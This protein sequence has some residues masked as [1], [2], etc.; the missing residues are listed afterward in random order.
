MNAK[1]TRSTPAQPVTDWARHQ[2]GVY[3]VYTAKQLRGDASSDAVL[4]KMKKSY[5]A[6]RAGDLVVVLKPY[7]LLSTYVT[8]TSHGTPHEYDTHV[9]L[10]VYG[11]GVPGGRRTEKVAPQQACPIVADFLGVAPPKTCEYGLP[12]TLAKP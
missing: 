6:D 2:D 11:P 10:L 5:Y 7:Y 8:G 9:P 4:A 3:R 12:A 1:R